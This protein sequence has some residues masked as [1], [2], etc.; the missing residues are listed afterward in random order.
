MKWE[1]KGF[2]S[3]MVEMTAPAGHVPTILE[4]VYAEAGLPVLGAPTAA[5]KRGAA[6]NRRTITRLRRTITNSAPAIASPL[7][8]HRSP[9]FART[10]TGA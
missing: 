6:V 3:N 1:E 7:A 9:E 10:Y 2:V 5:E 4:A 8:G